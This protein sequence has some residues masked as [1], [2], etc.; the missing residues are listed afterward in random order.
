MT[1]GGSVD[2]LT[3]ETLRSLFQCTTDGV[4]GV[5][6]DQRIVVWN[7]AAETLLGYRAREV[8]GRHCFEIMRGVGE[9]GCPVCGS[10]CPVFARASSLET[11]CTGNLHV[12]TKQ[13][14]M[15]WLSVSTVALPRQWRPDT[16]LVHLFRDVSTDK[17]CR[18]AVGNL[19]TRISGPAPAMQVGLLTP[20]DR[21]AVAGGL[22][23]REHEVLRH[24]AAGMS[25]RELAETLSVSISTVRN[26]IH[27]ILSKL[28]V[29]SRTE[30]VMVALRK[31]IL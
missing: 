2:G 17:S 3:M 29:H 12:R 9:D 5:S 11:V 13:G 31:G 25:T 8:L 22:T 18:D 19:L 6:S 23:D 16:V 21:P 20:A 27:N 7:R 4:C 26:H 15:L 1:A 24:L 30:A 10:R 14:N 28:K